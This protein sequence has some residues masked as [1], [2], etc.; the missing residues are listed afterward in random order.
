MR[1]F[2][3]EKKIYV[4]ASLKFHPQKLGNSEAKRTGSILRLRN[5]EAKITGSTVI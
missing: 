5:M 1:N 4:F 3:F 2:F